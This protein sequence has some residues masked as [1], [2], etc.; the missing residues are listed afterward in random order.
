MNQTSYLDGLIHV[1][2][3]GADVSI[4]CFSGPV[5]GDRFHFFRS[6]DDVD[7]NV[8]YVKESIPGWFQYGLPGAEGY[9]GLKLFLESLLKELGSKKLYCFGASMG[10]YGALLYGTL[11]DAKRILTFGARSYIHSNFVTNSRNCRSFSTFGLS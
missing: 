1:K 8:I 11:L 5:S 6:F 4:L 3:K 2:N 7:V 9:L 10:G